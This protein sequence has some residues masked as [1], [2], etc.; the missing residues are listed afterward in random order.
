VSYYGF[1]RGVPIISRG[2]THTHT[3]IILWIIIIINPTVR[4]I[5]V[6]MEYEN[7]EIPPQL[8][9]N[10]PGTWAHDTMTRRILEGL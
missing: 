10:I 7:H 1:G 8:R 9:A 4:F 6:I 3:E 5:V 2:D